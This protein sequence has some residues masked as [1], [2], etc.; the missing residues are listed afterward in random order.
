MEVDVFVGTS[1]L[2]FYGKCTEIEAAQKVFDGMRERNEVTWIAMVVGY[3]N[4]GE[5]G[6]AREMFDR[7]SNKNVV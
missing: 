6:G 5:M 3:V 1:L 4:L 7:M 2:D